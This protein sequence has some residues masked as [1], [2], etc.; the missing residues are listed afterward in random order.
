M[1]P[2]DEYNRNAPIA[3][4]GGSTAA[5]PGMSNAGKLKIKR[6]SHLF[7][8][9]IINGNILLK[10]IFYPQCDSIY[11]SKLYEIWKYWRITST[12]IYKSYSKSNK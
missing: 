6:K 4:G 9:K 2:Y 11:K 12:Y 3:R 1:N 10:Y 8:K 5:P 7:G